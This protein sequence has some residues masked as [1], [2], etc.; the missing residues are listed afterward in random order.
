MKSFTKI[1]LLF[2]LAF[3]YIDATSQTLPILPDPDYTNNHDAQITGI[4]TVGGTQPVAGIVAR[5]LRVVPGSPNTYFNVS[6]AISDANGEFTLKGISDV[7]YVIDYEYP[8]SGFTAQNANP[9]AAFLSL[10]HI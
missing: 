5:L 7:N 9:S 3:F 2:I 4:V 6:N 8:V 1:V 10:I